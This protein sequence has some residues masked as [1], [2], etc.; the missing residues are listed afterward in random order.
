MMRQFTITYLFGFATLLFFTA[1]SQ[2]EQAPEATA[3]PKLLATETALSIPTPTEELEMSEIRIGTPV[4]VDNIV[5]FGT[6]VG[7]FYAYDL[8][9]GHEKW[10]YETGRSALLAPLVE[11]GR[12]YFGGE[13]GNLYA[14]D[15]ETGEEIWKFAAGEVDYQIRDKY[16]NS[17][18]TIQDDIIYLRAK[19]LTS[20]LLMLRRAKRCG[21][22]SSKKKH[23]KLKH[24]LSMVSFT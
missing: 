3:Q 19:I 23:S 16:T 9:T 10:R 17:V 11:N 12:V 6:D 14:L 2:A 15:S 7:T 24:Q 18:P 5:Y 4:I 13:S 1:C 8:Q 21:A 20:M 22:S